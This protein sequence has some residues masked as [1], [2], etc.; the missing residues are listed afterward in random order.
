[1]MTYIMGALK[2]ALLVILGLAFLLYIPQ[3]IKFLKGE[4]K[5]MNKKMIAGKVMKW[6]GGFAG[7][8][9]LAFYG[10][11]FLAHVQ[12]VLTQILPLAVV[13]TICVIGGIICF[14]VGNR[15][16]NNN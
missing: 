16:E 1:M 5:T 12:G 13:G 7:V 6:V 10:G 11:A 8:L 2:I 9:G 15:K 14:V 3:I 4:Y